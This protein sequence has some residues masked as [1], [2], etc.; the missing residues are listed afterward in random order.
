MEHLLTRHTL[1]GF[2]LRQGIEA[3]AHRLVTVLKLNDVRVAWTPIETAAINASGDLMLADV[4]DDATVNRAL[5]V[6]YAGFVLHEL[7]HRKYTDFSAQAQDQY[8]AALHNAVEDAFIE[9]TCVKAGL[10]GNAKGLLGELI[11]TMTR[12][13][14]DA[15]KD[16]AD[17]RQYPYALAVCLRDHAT[18]GVPLAGGLEPIFAGA[19]VRLNN[20]RSSHDTLTIAQWVLAQL[21]G[22]PQQPKQPKGKD[23]GGDKADDKAGEGDAE[24]DAEGN[25]GGDGE[26]ES[27]GKGDKQVGKATAPTKNTRARK[28]EPTL[29]ASEN[30]G[31]G[32]SY[33]GD[34]QLRK[35]GYHLRPN[36]YLQVP[37]VAAP[38]KLRAEVR[39]LF[40]N[41]D[42]SGYDHNRKSGS[43]N[44][45]A[46]HKVGAGSDRV[47]KRRWEQ[48]GIDSAVV[49]LLDVSGSMFPDNIKGAVQTC[50]ALVDSLIAAGVTVS[51]MTFG[52]N[53]SV[54]LPFGSPA[55]RIKT[56][57][58][59][60]GD[61]GGTDDASALR[62]AHNAL[63]ARQEQRKVCFVLTD[64][65]GDFDGVRKQ[66]ASGT[67]LGITTI[68]VGIGWGATVEGVYTN[69]VNVQTPAA[70]ATT[71]LK[72]IKVAA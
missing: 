36:A 38:A 3:F 29:Q 72:Q 10:V 4:A 70:L 7:L 27:K 24:G 62:H 13:A 42:R 48:E 15:V 21:K 1:K 17:P 56:A 32:G 46:L 20:A 69:P 53:V 11:D 25:A 16:W 59:R 49:I 45:N 66:C 2:E 35:T 9:N 41:S 31:G 51:V 34:A 47:F 5:I 68:G 43:I 28:V 39:A 57:M 30:A 18:V 44:A 6:R 12:E 54:A 55:N 8:L 23:K 40:D 65:N 67:A 33:F 19:G 61:G 14:L 60:V 37:P 22:L 26:G 50:D 52:C 71:A 64:G 58:R 63:L